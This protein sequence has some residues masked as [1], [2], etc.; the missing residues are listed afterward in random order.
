MKKLLTLFAIGLIILT[1]CMSSTKNSVLP[2]FEVTQVPNGI[3][4][5]VTDSGATIL[6]N[7]GQQYWQLSLTD[8]LNSLHFETRLGG[9]TLYLTK[10]SNNY[11]VLDSLKDRH[12]NNVYKIPTN[13]SLI[14]LIKNDTI[15]KMLLK[16][17]SIIGTNTH[18][19]L[20][21]N[22]SLVFT[23]N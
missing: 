14:S 5:Y 7:W 18:P 4:K 15:M 16:D 12:I 22:D 11:L 8:T 10:T 21:K 6:R 1:S 19:I 20:G 9:P 17:L 23:K 13:D 2:N 3:Y